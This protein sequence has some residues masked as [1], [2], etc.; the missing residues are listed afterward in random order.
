MMRNTA[1]VALIRKE[2]AH[3]AY[4]AS[5]ILGHA[6]TDTTRKHY[7]DVHGSMLVRRD[8]QLSELID[9]EEITDQDLADIVEIL[10]RDPDEWTVLMQALHK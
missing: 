1:T 5:K 6:S 3:G 4:K 2:N 10:K 7:T 9:K 8:W